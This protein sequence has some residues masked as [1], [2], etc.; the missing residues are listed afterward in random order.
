MPACRAGSIKLTSGSS[1]GFLGADSGR[2]SSSGL[3]L[4]E[5][6]L[7]GGLESEGLH[8]LASLIEGCPLVKNIVEWRWGT[9]ANVLRGDRQMAAFLL[10]FLS[11]RCAEKVEGSNRRQFSL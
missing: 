7:A 11:P 6:G 3:K 2:G 5:G 9:F 10:C 1:A 4:I 8:A